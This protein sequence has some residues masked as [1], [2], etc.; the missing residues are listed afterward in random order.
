MRRVILVS[1]FLLFVFLL[2]QV[3]AEDI[4]IVGAGTYDTGTGSWSDTELLGFGGRFYP[5]PWGQGSYLGFGGGFTPYPAPGGFGDYM[6]FGGRFYPRPWGQGSYLGAPETGKEYIDWAEVPV[7]TTVRALQ[8]GCFT[9]STEPIG[10]RL[11]LYGGMDDVHEGTLLKTLD[12]AVQT[13]A[14]AHTFSDIQC[15]LTFVDLRGGNEVFLGSEHDNDNDGFAAVGYSYEFTSLGNGT[16]VDI[17]RGTYADPGWTLPGGSIQ[18]MTREYAVTDISS[19]VR[20]YYDAPPDEEGFQLFMG[21]SS[22]PEPTSLGLLAIGGLTL[23]GLA[24][25]KRRRR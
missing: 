14:P 10:L 2:N 20:T 1:C 11:R 22:V 24:L 4:A 7:D 17:V 13:Y 16:G 15:A 25:V 12:V 3:Q 19:G 23:G 21:M 8:I 5:R 18:G 9:D 6:G